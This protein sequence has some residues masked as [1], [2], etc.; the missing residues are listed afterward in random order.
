MSLEQHALGRQRHDLEGTD[1]WPDHCWTTTNSVRLWIRGDKS[2]NNRTFG[3]ARIRKSGAKRFGQP[4]VFKMMPVFDFTGIVNFD[5]LSTNQ[6]Y[7]YQ[8]GYVFAD[9]EPDD[10][11]ISSKDDWSDAAHGTLRTAVSNSTDHTSFIFG[12]M[13]VLVAPVRRV[14]L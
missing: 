1:C 11:S 7:D 5:G 13:S 12:F 3:V 2:S 4:K 14:I 10:L 9:G 8:I 6:G